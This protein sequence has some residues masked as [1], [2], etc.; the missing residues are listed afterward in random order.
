[1]TSKKLFSALALFWIIIIFGFIGYK[2]YTLKTG[3]EV[4]LN[5]VPIDPRDLFRGDYVVLRYEI[6]NLDPEIFDTN[7]VTFKPG[8]KVYVALDTTDGFGKATGIYLIPPNQGLYIKGV[9]KSSWMNSVEIEY[10]IESYFVPEGRGR[11]IE[12]AFDKDIDVRIMVDK[13]GRSVIKA[14][15]I[16]GEVVRF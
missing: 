1:M 10:G 14:L 3:E 2:E 12:N 13:S 15:L 7:D 6:S 16:D 11:E 8:D 5:T 4:L 9:A